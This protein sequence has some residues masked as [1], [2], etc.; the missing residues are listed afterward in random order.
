MRSMT[1]YAEATRPLQSGRV[2]MSL[3]SVNGKGLD[4][5]LRLHPAL[6]SLEAA[7]RAK[8]RDRALRGKLDLA[9]EVL[10]EAALEPRINRPLLRSI[11]KA[12][13]EEAE[14]LKLPPFTPEAFFRLPGAWMPAD[15]DLAAHLESAVMACLEDLLA[16]WNKAR[17]AEGARLDP[18][19]R[20]G[21]A[22]LRACC[23]A[24]SS[25]AL[26]QAAELPVLFQQRIAKVLEEANLKGELPAERLLAEAGVLA[27]RQDVRE[28]LV[29]LAS[30]LDDLQVRLEARTLG[31]KAL[32]VWCQE[33]L[34]ELNTIGSKCR[35]LA[36][37]RLV[38][39]GK[40][41]LDQLRE[42]AANLE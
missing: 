2:R 13:A 40:Q 30:H 21:A 39:E 25:E 20:E 8:V 24:L 1:A 32:D 23:D 7:L 9:V 37:T 17:E 11:A 41:T 33:V 28:E 3:R 35:R 10:D 38:M 16:S 4:L 19:F 34:R 36:M 42:Q 31:G 14:W 5:N 15:S 29:R 22:R 6:F 26:A 18:F 12:W 27:E